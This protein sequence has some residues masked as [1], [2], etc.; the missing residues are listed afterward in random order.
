MP[1]RIVIEARS[2]LVFPARKP[3]AQFTPSLSYVPGRVIWGALGSRLR[4]TPTAR[5]SNAL[6]AHRGDAWVRVVRQR[7]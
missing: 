2:P 1:H 5:F 6:P 7:R 4:R 3:G